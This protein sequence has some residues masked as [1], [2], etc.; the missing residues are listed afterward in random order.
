MHKNIPLYT[1]VLIMI[2]AARANVI[3]ILIGRNKLTFINNHG[4]GQTSL[5]P[6]AIIFLV[7]VISKIFKITKST[8]KNMFI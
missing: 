4:S 6:R 3:I 7:V 1:S 2:N 5:P 8:A